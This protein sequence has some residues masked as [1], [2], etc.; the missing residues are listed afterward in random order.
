VPAFAII[1]CMMPRQ[2]LVYGSSLLLSLVAESLAQDSG[3]RV[4]RAETWENASRSL[5][6]RMPDVLIF[7]L[8]N[9]SEGHVLPLLLKNRNLLLIGLDSEQNQAMLL[10]SRKAHSLTLRQLEEIVRTEALLPGEPP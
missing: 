6:E 10:S 1:T 2:V 5:S 7:D 4:T 3:L 8:V 9:S